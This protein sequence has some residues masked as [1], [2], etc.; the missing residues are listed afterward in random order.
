MVAC[1]LLLY[2]SFYTQFLCL[3]SS[4]TL[5]DRMCLSGSHAS[6]FYAMSS[7]LFA[8]TSSEKVKAAEPCRRLTVKES[9]WS[10]VLQEILLQSQCQ[11]L[12]YLWDSRCKSSQASVVC[13]LKWHLASIWM[14]PIETRTVCSIWKE[15]VQKLQ[16]ASTCSMRQL[17]IPFLSITWWNIAVQS[18][19]KANWPYVIKAYQ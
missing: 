8:G 15:V 12:T 16:A 3:F 5:N 17:W 18:S 4:L 6:M 19:C 11:W 13:L 1:S 9:L 7:S 14:W 10:Q 2:Q